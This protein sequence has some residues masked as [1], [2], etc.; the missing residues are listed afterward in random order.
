MNALNP[1]QSRIL[2]LM[3]LLLLV[4]ALFV[5]ILQPLYNRY[6]TASDEIDRLEHQIAVYTRVASGL[7]ESEAELDS[8]LQNNPI[9]DLYLAETKPTLAAAELQQQLNRMVS[10]SGG[11]VVSTQIL[12]RNTDTVLPTV[13]LQ[14]HVR[15][16][17]DELVRLLHQVESGKPLL[18]IENLVISSVAR[19]PVQRA[20]RARQRQQ[21]NRV[22]PSLDVR[23]DLIGHSGKEG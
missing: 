15:S 7:M 1:K 8:L 21:L 23:F 11:Q 3:I 18:F 6:V 17:I 22:L 12:Q 5:L 13:S 9:A 10:Q 19:R 20:N 4:V 14:V 2:A 16:E